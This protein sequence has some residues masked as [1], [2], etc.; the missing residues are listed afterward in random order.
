MC[1][2]VEQTSYSMLPLSTLQWWVPGEMKTA[3]LGRLALAAENMLSRRD[4][5]KG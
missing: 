3:E 2:S 4:E 5:I 1:R